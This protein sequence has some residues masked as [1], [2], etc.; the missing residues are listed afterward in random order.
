M[1][2]LWKFL[3][4]ILIIGLALAIKWIITANCLDMKFADYMAQVVWPAIKNAFTAI[5]EAIKS[6]YKLP[7]A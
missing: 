3:L 5:W 4:V 7:G 6:L 2:G 1:K